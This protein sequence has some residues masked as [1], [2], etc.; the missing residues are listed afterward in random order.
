M[1]PSKASAT[2]AVDDLDADDLGRLAGREDE[3][4]LGDGVVGVAVVAAARGAAQGLVL[5]PGRGQAGNRQPDDEID[6][7]VDLTDGQVS[8]CDN[9]RLRDPRERRSSRS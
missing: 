5:D 2:G 8:R 1:N 3:L 6:E 9:G 7:A 4:A